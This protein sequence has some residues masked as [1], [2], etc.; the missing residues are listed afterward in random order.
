M[1]NSKATP[2]SAVLGGDKVKS[3]Q[4]KKSV[5]GRL[6]IQ[7]AHEDI[8]EVKRSRGGLCCLQRWI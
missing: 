3:S 1:K 6:G 7:R 8:V 2:I 4:Q 5:L